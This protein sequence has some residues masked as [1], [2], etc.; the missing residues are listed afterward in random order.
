MKVYNIA[1]VAF[2]LNFRSS[3]VYLQ[4]NLIIIFQDVQ[5][6]LQ[7]GRY[8]EYTNEFTLINFEINT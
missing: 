2:L 6:T 4:T 1:L 7:R 5:I 8:I 3:Y